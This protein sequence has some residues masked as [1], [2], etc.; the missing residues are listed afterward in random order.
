MSSPI[1]NPAAWLRAVEHADGL[2]AV[3]AWRFLRR[4]HGWLVDRWCV[5][6]AA[7]AALPHAGRGCQY[8]FAQVARF[9]RE[10]NLAFRWSYRSV[11]ETVLRPNPSGQ[12]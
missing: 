2:A 5:E 8:T 12:H 1:T 9:A 7:D 10:H 11:L 4:R 3:P 6:A